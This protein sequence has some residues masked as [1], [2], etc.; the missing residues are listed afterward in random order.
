M[1]RGQALAPAVPAIAPC[2]HRTASYGSLPAAPDWRW[3]PI[4]P[5]QESAP[6]PDGHPYFSNPTIRAENPALLP[7]N[8]EFPA[9][10][11]R[12]DLQRWHISRPSSRSAQI[13]P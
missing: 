13:E 12:W 11:S 9:R 4:P 6:N 7:G 1:Y 3:E 8:R 10:S 5:I 2:S